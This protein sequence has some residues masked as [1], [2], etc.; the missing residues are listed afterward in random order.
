MHGHTPP[1]LFAMHDAA[2]PGTLGEHLQA[3]GRRWRVYRGFLLVVVL[4]MAAAALYLGP[5]ASSQY[6]SE[7][8]FVVRSVA[9]GQAAASG[10]APLLGMANA[11]PPSQ[12]ESLALGDYLTSHD[13]VA[14]LERRLGLASLF[15]R[16][17]I[18]PLSRLG[19]APTPETLLK[20]Y[21][22]QVKLHYSGETGITTMKVRAFRPDDAYRIAATLLDLGEARVNALN[23][24]AFDDAL[25]AARAQLADAEA[26]LTGVREQITALRQDDRD[27]DPIRSGAAQIDLAAGLRGQLATA[28]AQLETMRG[29]LSPAAP[30][31]RVAARRVAALAAQVGAEQ[32]RMAGAPRS[33]ATGLGRYEALKLR[34]DF[35]AKRYSAAAAALE[36]AREQA[37]RQQLFV[38]RVVAPNHP[39]KSLYPERWWTLFSIFMGLLLVYA[40]GWLIAAGVRE[41]AS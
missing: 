35:A 38:V 12:T 25:R 29:S 6:V 1:E 24:R 5:I 20:Y 39:V 10:I 31:V 32:G 33:M 26:D 16:P 4:P 34:E 8:H 27:I 14:A 40:I 21:R 36:S 3:L 17:G 15:R 9:S 11:M 22:G 7:A 41:H 30:Q 28:K 13:A 19:A 37:S 23:Q 18:D 2:K